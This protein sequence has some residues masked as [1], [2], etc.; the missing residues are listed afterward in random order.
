M[1]LLL[2]GRDGSDP[3]VSYCSGSISVSLS[4][5]LGGHYRLIAIIDFVNSIIRGHP[6]KY[7]C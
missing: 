4:L 1:V 3:F 2:I 7:R 6:L 5:F